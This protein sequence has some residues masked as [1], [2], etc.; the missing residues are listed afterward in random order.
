LLKVKIG[1]KKSQKNKQI[2]HKN[3]VLNK[4]AEKI[5]SQ[6]FLKKNTIF[7]IFWGSQI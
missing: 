6:L 4:V 7:F 2:G 1:T 3:M 5:E